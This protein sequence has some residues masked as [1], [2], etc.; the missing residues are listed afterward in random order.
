MAWQKP[1]PDNK[2]NSEQNSNMSSH[3]LLH[4]I[5]RLWKVNRH[6]ISSQNNTNWINHPCFSSFYKFSISRDLIRKATT[7]FVS[8]LLLCCSSAKVVHSNS[9]I[10][11]F[12]KLQLVT[13]LSTVAARE[14]SGKCQHSI[15]IIFPLRVN[16][17][18]FSPEKYEV[19]F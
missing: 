1:N 15:L 14:Q 5:P 18:S 4:L 7:G 16:L 9:R 12:L 8:A 17:D 3:A 13:W 2:V 19:C 6:R 10:A 11:D